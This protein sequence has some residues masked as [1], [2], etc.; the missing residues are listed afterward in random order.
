MPAPSTIL[1]NVATAIASLTG[2]TRLG[3]DLSTAVERIPAGALRFQMKCIVSAVNLNSNDSRPVLY[4]A[5]SVHR[6][7]A[8]GEAERTYTEGARL[9][10]QQSLVDP[11]WWFAIGGLHT[12]VYGIANGGAPN[13]ALSDLTRDGDGEVISYTITVGVVCVTP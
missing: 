6:R 7:L 13:T 8:A 2:G 10:H 3:S 12:N 1:G 5:V 9:T 4:L 11:Q